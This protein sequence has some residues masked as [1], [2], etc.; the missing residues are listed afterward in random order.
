MSDLNRIK[1]LAGLNEAPYGNWEA[2][3]V[4]TQFDHMRK[5]AEQLG[6]MARPAN[7]GGGFAKS[8]EAIGGDSSYL[9]DIYQAA[10]DLHRAI[11]EADHGARAHLDVE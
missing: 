4:A 3:Q 11:D 7:E 9:A 6:A 8:I 2:K 10:E 1:K 5:L